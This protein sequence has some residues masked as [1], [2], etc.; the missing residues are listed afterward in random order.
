M[1]IAIALLIGALELTGKGINR[2]IHKLEK[3]FPNA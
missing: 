1:D 3:A 2:L